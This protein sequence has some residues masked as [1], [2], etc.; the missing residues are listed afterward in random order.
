MRTVF[1]SHHRLDIGNRNWEREIERRSEYRLS[2]EV[3]LVVLKHLTFVTEQLKRNFTLRRLVKV[4]IVQ[5]F[6][7]ER[8]SAE[9][10]F[11]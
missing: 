11:L 8:E 3:R 9:P 4:P 2:I 1:P 6:V 7:I 10:K 5:H